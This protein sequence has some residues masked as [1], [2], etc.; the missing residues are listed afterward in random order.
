MKKNRKNLEILIVILFVFIMGIVLLRQ[1]FSIKVPESLNYTENGNV[2]YKVH[3]NDSK[4]YGTNYLNEGMQYISSIIDYIDISFNYNIKFDKNINYNAETNTFANIKIVD[5]NNSDKVIY[6][7]KEIINKDNINKNNDSSINTSSKIKIDYKKY[8]DITNEFKT[9]YGISANCKLLVDYYINY[10]GNYND[11]SN[12]NKTKK[13]S[14]EIPLSE[15]MINISKTPSF[16]NNSQY[17]ENSNKTIA[18]KTLFSVSIVFIL[19]SIITLIFEIITIIKEHDTDTKYDKYLK[20]ILRHYDSYITE[21]DK[22]IDIEDKTI[23]NVNS[24]K[25]L[26]DVR[27]NIEKAIVFNKINENNAKFMIIDDNEIYC[28]KVNSKDFN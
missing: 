3:L 2:N 22:Q 5:S 15:Q 7:S 24:F 26:M 18:N 9:R 12:I 10:N 20:K 6:S 4:Y 1:S 8:N 11:F 16:S 14:V 23:I 25:E 13:L 19:T 21:S 17:I 27:N 28:F